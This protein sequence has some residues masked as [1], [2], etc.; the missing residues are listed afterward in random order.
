M[1]T[2]L[3]GAAPQV[4]QTHEVDPAP[5]LDRIRSLQ[6]ERDMLLLRARELERLTRERPA[7]LERLSE[8]ETEL[9]VVPGLRDRLDEALDALAAVAG[10]HLAETEIAELYARNQDLSREL[11]TVQNENQRLQAVM[12]RTY[13]SLSWRITVP[14]RAAKR[15]FDR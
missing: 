7:L 6:E 3:S 9:A 8:L 4:G 1:N 12:R 15:L 2:E 5:L 10:P 14:L 13:R 11:E